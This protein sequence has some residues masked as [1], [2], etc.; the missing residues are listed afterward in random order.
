[1]GRGD[2]AL[3]LENGRKWCVL[4]HAPVLASPGTNPEVTLEP[5]MLGGWTPGVEGVPEVAH[6]APVR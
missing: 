2:S 1:M 5:G 3:P 4:D 6:V